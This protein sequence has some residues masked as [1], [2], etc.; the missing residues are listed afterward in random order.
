MPKIEPST[1]I[2]KSFG[3]NYPRYANKGQ[4]GLM[5]LMYKRT[6]RDG[7]IASAYTRPELGALM[8][9]RCVESPT[10]AHI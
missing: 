4:E 8:F 5:A 6:Q 7:Q 9:G 10:R 3:E 2:N 1:P